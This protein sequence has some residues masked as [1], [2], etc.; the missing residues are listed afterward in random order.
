MQRVEYLV[1][2]DQKD[3]FCAS[4][5]A[6]NNLIKSIDG[7]SLNK[8]ALR[9]KDLSFEYEVQTGEISSDK[10][11][12]FHVKFTCP[13]LATYDVF[14]IL[15][16]S[17]RTVLTKA[18]GRPVQ[19][20]WDDLSFQYARNAYPLIYELENLLRKLI[21]KF[22]LINVGLGWTNEA[23]PKE[24]AESV[25]TKGA[26]LDQ[27]YLYEVD[28]IQLSNFL[29]KEYATINSIAVIEKLKKAGTTYD[30]DLAELK[31]AIPSSNWDRYFSSV[32]NC[33]SEYL[34]IRWERLYDRRNQIAHNR[35]LG[36]VEYEEIVSLC[37]EL[38]PK[39]QHAIDNLDQIFVSEHDREFVSENAAVTKTSGYRDFL[40]AWNELHRILSAL[41]SATAKAEKDP[42]KLLQL[43][44]NVRA[45]LNRLRRY[46]VLSPE[47]RERILTLMQLRNVLVH[48]TDVMVPESTLALRIEE[49]LTI[50]S[51]LNSKLGKLSA[52]TSEPLTEEP[53][54]EDADE[55]VEVLSGPQKTQ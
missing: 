21:T 13:D 31:Q 43:Q 28:F 50:S 27:N 14:E 32:V 11:R 19:T 55:E 41:S 16:K 29:F 52:G 33:D 24:V 51:A 2:I 6:F 8:S 26:K 44:K 36:R 10:Q 47:E 54:L 30:L 35:P 1:T 25:R 53:G 40:A 5:T 34:R 20:V 18:S 7:I 45:S 49:I 4:V 46:G 42:S 12:F 38:K 22:M 39:I 3:S 23:I 9:F 48:Q 17:V 37:D 15:L